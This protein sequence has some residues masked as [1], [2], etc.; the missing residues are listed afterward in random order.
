[1]AGGQFRSGYRFWEQVEY[2]SSMSN[3]YYDGGH[4]YLIC[5]L[6]SGRYVFILVQC[7]QFISTAKPLS[8]V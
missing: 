5:D 6:V 3:V 1:M 7:A 2:S 4:P 8:D